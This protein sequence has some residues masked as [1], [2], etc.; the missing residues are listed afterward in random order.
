MMKQQ[1]V[2][3]LAC[4]WTWSNLVDSRGLP[5]TG[6][7]LT[8]L[9]NYQQEAGLDRD[10]LGFLEEL[11]AWIKTADMDISNMTADISVIEVRIGI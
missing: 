11:S 5:S 9:E 10:D 3:L 7:L 6:K 2:L 8:M 1:L 4:F